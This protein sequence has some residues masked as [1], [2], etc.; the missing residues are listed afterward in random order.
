MH[1]SP[2]STIAKF[3]PVMVDLPGRRYMGRYPGTLFAMKYN[4][5]VA[6]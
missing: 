3:T 2:E 6:V 4:H 1:V 5:F